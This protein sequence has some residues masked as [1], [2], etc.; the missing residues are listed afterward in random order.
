MQS[1]PKKWLEMELQVTFK[2]QVQ[3]KFELEPDWTDGPVLGS[4]IWQNWT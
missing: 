4:A 1:M 3:T 2:L